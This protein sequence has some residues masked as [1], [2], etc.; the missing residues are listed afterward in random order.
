MVIRRDTS[1]D[2]NFKHKPPQVGDVMWHLSSES[3]VEVIEVNEKYGWFKVQFP[4][5][6]IRKFSSTGGSNCLFRYLTPEQFADHRLAQ[7]NTNP[8]DSWR[9]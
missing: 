4:N 2:V 1:L 7:A 9:E 5:G 6:V 8:N 3:I